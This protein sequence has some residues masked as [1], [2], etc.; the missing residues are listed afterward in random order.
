MAHKTLIDGTA[1]EISGG[2]TL[3]NG[4]VYSIKNGK[5]LVDGTAYDV[6]FVV[7]GG[8]VVLEV[9]KITS[10]TYAN[11]TTY[12]AEEFILLD[13]YPKTGGTVTVTYGGL[14]KTITDTSGAE[15]PN[16]QQV[17]FGTFNGVSDSVATPASGELTIK[18]DY[19]AFCNSAFSASKLLS[20]KNSGNITS[21]K[22][23]GEITLI[24]ASAFNSALR[25]EAITI[26]NGV[27]SIGGRAFAGCMNLLS[28]TIPQSVTMIGTNPFATIEKNN[29]VSV[30]NGNT[31]YKIDGNGLIEIA[32][33]RLVSG[34]L[35][36]VIPSYVELIGDYAYYSMPVN[37]I[38]IPSGVT[39]I[40]SYAFNG[41]DLTNVYIP[42]SVKCIAPYA[43]ANC[44][45]LT[46]ITFEEPLD[47]TN[48]WRFCSEEDWYG[49]SDTDMRDPAKNVTLICTTYNSSYLMRK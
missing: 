19:Y 6:I 12:T 44:P 46:S 42:K 32:T 23:W 33:N 48:G 49:G 39:K 40:G 38:T 2:K 43:F 45:N 3:V 20:G 47:G 25:D 27:I 34:F 17:F 7:G 15:E 16:A 1:Y 24:P 37:S 36:T 28:A 10:D 30:C 4:T 13:I 29:F 31:A 22:H 14:T 5:T 11:E 41:T 21:I 8:K 26:P 18:G 9:E 35:N